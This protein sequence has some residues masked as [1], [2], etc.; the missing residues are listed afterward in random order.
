MK[1]RYLDMESDPLQYEKYCKS[2]DAANPA[3]LR[4]SA[5]NFAKQLDRLAKLTGTQRE[6]LQ[7]Q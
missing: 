1:K 2:L 6:E 5:L 3:R 4:R 7:R